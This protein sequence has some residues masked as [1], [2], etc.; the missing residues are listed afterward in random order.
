MK[1][2]FL[3]C[4]IVLCCPVF[5]LPVL[6]SNPDVVISEIMI[7]EEGASDNE[8]IKLSNNSDTDIALD[9]FAL[10]KKTQ[11][12]TE[13]SLVSSAKF[14]G[15]IKARGSFVIA[16]PGYENFASDLVYSGS[17]YYIS[18]NNTIILYDAGGNILDK[19]GY[20]EAGD[21][22]GAPAADIEAGQ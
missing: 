5:A 6:A 9:G 1:K 2:T 11:S 19:V 13:S 18:A 16:N 22:E 21:F 10:K 12:G 17:S 15:V 7:G 4:F 8:Y 14:M 3:F 20:G